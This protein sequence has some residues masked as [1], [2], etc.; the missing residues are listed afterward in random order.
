MIVSQLKSG[1]F[2]YSPRQEYH[3]VLE[4][5]AP[6]AVVSYEQRRRYMIV[7]FHDEDCIFEPLPGL[8]VAVI[9]NNKAK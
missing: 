5:S 3:L 1:D 9:A 8:F 4:Y 6:Y 7:I 2:P